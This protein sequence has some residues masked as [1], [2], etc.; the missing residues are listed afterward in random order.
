MEKKQ[1][2]TES[3]KLLDMMINSVYT[4]KEIFLREIISNASDAIDKRHF[5]SLTDQKYSLKNGSFEIFISV[6]KDKR[7]ITISDNGIGMDKDE[8]ENNLG[9][10]A[11]SGSFDF[12][13]DDEAKGKT[14]IIGQFGV[15]FYSAFMVA[16]SIIVNTKKVDSDKAYTWQS[17][18]V[19]GFT[20]DETNKDDIGTEIILHLRADNDD[21]KYSEYLEEFRIR[22]LISKYSNYIKYPIKMEVTKSRLKEGSKDEYEDYK[23][24]EVLNSMTPLWNKSPKDIKKEEYSSF[25][26]EKF[27]DFE[28]PLHTIHFSSDGMPSFKA[29]MFIPSRAPFDY[30]SKTFEKGLELYSSGVLIMD[31]CADLLPDYFSFVKGVVDSPDLSLNISR[32]MLQHNKQLKVIA[33]GLEKKIKNELT[34]LLESDRTSYEKFYD[35]FGLQ[36]KYGIYSSYGMNNE[37]LKDLI[38]FVSSYE[39]KKVTLK[40]YVSRMKSDQKQIY[41]ASGS[42]IDAV[43]MLPQ[44]EAVKEKGF[45]VLYLTAEIDEFSIKALREYDGHEFLNVTDKSLDIDSKEDKEKLKEENEKSATVFDFMKKELGDKVDSVRFSSVLKNHPVCLSTEGSVSL[46]MEN[47]L[48][49]MPGGDNDVKAKA[50]LEIN[51]NHPIASKIKSLYETDKDK[52]AKYTKILYSQA[53]LIGGMKID[54]PSELSDLVCSLMAD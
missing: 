45:E 25:Y 13:Q 42:S 34:K 32:E 18:G 30:Y 8:L 40:E 51:L 21:E 7:T 5:L 52:L 43:K 53:R 47:V 29:L 16:D 36:L 41:Y 54:N 24:V 12:K 11:K 37:T 38:M 15:G 33:G 2:Q 20:I 17:S 14:D 31:K 35:A 46:E 44:A 4:H 9:T 27:Y 10:I 49:S 23:E 22:N 50:I 48:N 19:D 28:D 26:K 6:D 1:F 39:E 3:K